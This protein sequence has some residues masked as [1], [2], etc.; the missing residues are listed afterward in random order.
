MCSSDL[1][2]KIPEERHIS[3]IGKHLRAIG[4]VGGKRRV[5]VIDTGADISMLSQASVTDCSKIR[6]LQKLDGNVTGVGGK[7]VLLGIVIE[8]VKLGPVTAQCEFYVCIDP[9]FEVILGANF[10]YSH[11]L[12]V[13]PTMH[14]IVCENHNGALVPLLGTCPTAVFSCRVRDRKSVV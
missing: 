6:P 5:I 7:S 13:S 4:Y 3:V 10:V 12:G 1:Y 14:S 9:G 8:E 11:M 2:E